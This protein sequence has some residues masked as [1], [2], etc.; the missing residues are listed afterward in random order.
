MRSSSLHLLIKASFRRYARLLAYL[1]SLP[2]LIL[3][4]WQSV[5]SPRYLVVPFLTQGLA[6]IRGRRET[7]KE[8]ISVLGSQVVSKDAEIDAKVVQFD[9]LKVGDTIV[10][11]GTSLMSTTIRDHGPLLCTAEA[12]RY[13]PKRALHSYESQL[14]FICASKSSV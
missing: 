5:L 1:F 2:L 10:E 8:C 3:F 13:S 7:S 9:R 6:R 14:Q 11:E 4:V 12:A